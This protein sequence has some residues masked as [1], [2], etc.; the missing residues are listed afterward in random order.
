[1]EHWGGKPKKAKLTATGN[2]QVIV[3]QNT[4]YIL[5]N[6]IYITN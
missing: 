5:P 3:F 6:E 4:K 1:M 2:L